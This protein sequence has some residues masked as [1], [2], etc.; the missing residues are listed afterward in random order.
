MEKDDD[1][2]QGYDE[3][4]ETEQ[5]NRQEINVEAKE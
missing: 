5:E 1:V 2:L 4:K 3:K